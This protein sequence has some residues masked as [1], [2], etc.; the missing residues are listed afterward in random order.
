MKDGTPRRSD[1]QAWFNRQKAKL[2]VKIDELRTDFGSLLVSNN[3]IYRAIKSQE[4]RLK[5]LRTK[6]EDAQRAVDDLDDEVD[7]MTV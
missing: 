6:L 5:D 3:D 7:G 1:I 2:K 4:A